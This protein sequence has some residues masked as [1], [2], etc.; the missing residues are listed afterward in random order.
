MPRFSSQRLHRSTYLAQPAA[1]GRRCP[2]QAVPIAHLPSQSTTTNLSVFDS[3]ARESDKCRPPPAA[4]KQQ[5]LSRSCSHAHAHSSPASISRTASSELQWWSPAAP[6]SIIY[7]YIY[8]APNHRGSY[9]WCC[10]LPAA[11][12][13]S[14]SVRSQ[15]KWKQPFCCSQ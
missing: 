13:Q 4:S 2:V 15:S 11:S 3:R 8:E 9:Y 12:V 5:Q 1:V 14:Y 6:S 10:C 7:I